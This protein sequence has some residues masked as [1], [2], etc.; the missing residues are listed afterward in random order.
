MK[1]EL[2]WSGTYTYRAERVHCPQTID[3]LRHLIET[4]SSSLHALGT[5]HSFNDIADAAALISLEALPGAVTI[6]EDARSVS[7]PAGM[8]YG[9]LARQLHQAGWALSNLPS[10]PHITVAGSV[11]TATHGSGSANQSLAS[12]VTA[13]SLISGSGDQLRIDHTSPDF[14]AAAVHLGALGVVTE[15]TLAIEP[16]F[17]VRQDVYEH[18]PWDH[19]TG[20]FEDVMGAGYS[21]SAITDFAGDDVDM[22]W[23]KSRLDNGQPTTMPTE[24]FEAR[25]A[26]KKLHVTRGNDPVH[27]TPQLGEPGPWCERLPHFLLEF[28]PSSGAEIQSEYLMD[29]QHAGAAL[30][31]LRELGHAIA[32][33]VKSAEIRTVAA[34]ELWLSPAYQRSSFGVH[35][36]WQPDGAAVEALV[37]RIEQVLQPFQPR[38]HWSK[39][40]GAGHDWS[41]LYPRLADFRRLA[42]A[43]DPRGVFRTP[44]LAR[45]V[46]GP[47]AP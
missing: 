27:C 30:E 41:G 7:V 23:V 9:D 35:F 32:P 22:L 16:T 18:L 13:M 37:E 28:T 38:P 44:F 24:L 11:A 33:A 5:R 2:N 46:L 4:A 43:Y 36:T 21:V 15:L 8:R 14:A 25:A 42:E 6:D 47:A 10:L 31:A 20:S 1:P 3:E 19:L 26:T 45:T 17:G 39:V 29:R 34:E 12:A 40:F